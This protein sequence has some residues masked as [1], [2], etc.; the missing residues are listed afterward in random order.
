MGLKF[1][2]HMDGMDELK[3]AFSKA[4]TKA[5]HT[6]AEEVLSDTAPFVPALTKSLTNRSH[7]E[8]NYVVYPG[9]Y[10]RYLYHGKVLVD[11]KIN[12][13]GF[14]T[15]EVWKSR[16]GSK[17]IETDRNLVFNKSVHPQAQAYWFE[18]SKAQN[19]E[20][21]KRAA[22]NVAKENFKK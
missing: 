20:K 9:P 14:L 3:K 4:C 8:G 12:A 7:V 1:K 21:W 6:V 15:D 22:E 2:V 16:Y 17:K 13:A 11:P 10:A 5:E 18:A 19:L